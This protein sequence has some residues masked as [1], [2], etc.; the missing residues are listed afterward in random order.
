[1]IDRREFVGSLAGPERIRRMRAAVEDEIRLARR[2]YGPARRHSVVGYEA[3]NHYYY[4]PLDL[5]E[6][7]IQCEQ[8][9]GK[10][11]I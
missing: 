3:S 10:L 1:M 8:L 6:K 7:I 9:L 5:A 4:R 11:R 2:T